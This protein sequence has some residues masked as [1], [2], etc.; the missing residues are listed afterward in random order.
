MK[1]IYSGC[2]LRVPN[3]QKNDHIDNDHDKCYLMTFAKDGTGLHHASENNTIWRWKYSSAIKPIRVDQSIIVICRVA[4][5]AWVSAP[6]ACIECFFECSGIGMNNVLEVIII[7]FL[8][9]MPFILQIINLHIERYQNI[10]KEIQPH[11]QNLKVYIIVNLFFFCFWL[12]RNGCWSCCAGCYLL[13]FACANYHRKGRIQS[14]P[15]CTRCNIKLII[16]SGEAMNVFNYEENRV[17]FQ[18]NGSANTGLY[19]K[20]SI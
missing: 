8:F 12:Q 6:I 5:C 10:Q 9:W 16:S 18:L 14:L 4:H 1:L 2:V 3:I 15:M 20:A 17:V 19:C 13:D 7:A 11:V